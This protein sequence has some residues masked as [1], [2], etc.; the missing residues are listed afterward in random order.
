MKTKQDGGHSDIMLQTKLIKGKAKFY[1]YKRKFQQ[2]FVN[3]E[4]RAGKE[5]H[6]ILAEC[7]EKM[8]EAIALLGISLDYDIL[9]DEGSKLLDWAM[10]DCVSI[11]NKLGVC[12]RCLLCR[13]QRELRDSHIWPNFIVDAI[14]APSSQKKDF[15]FGLHKHLFKSPGECTYQMLCERCEQLLSQNGESDFKA[16][17]PTSGEITYSAWLFN[18]C[19]GVIFR[20][21]SITCQFPMHFNDGEIHKVLLHCRK[22]LLSLPV[23]IGGKVASLGAYNKRDLEKLAQQLKDN[24]DIYLFMSPLKSRQNYGAFQTEYQS[25]AIA[26]SRDKQFNTKSLHFNGNAHFYL[27]CCGP[28]TLIVNFDQS[29]LSL[30]K[31][32][33]LITSN[34]IDSD[35]KYSIPSEEDFV[36]LLPV[37]VWPIMEQLAQ[38]T[39]ENFNRVTQYVSKRAKLP[40]TRPTIVA[41]SGSGSSTMADTQIPAIHSM[42]DS[43]MMFPVSFLPKEYDVI[44]PHLK[45]P[46]NQCVILPQGHWVIC[47]ATKTISALNQDMTFLVCVKPNPEEL[48]VIY[49][50]QN[51]TNHTLCM[52]GA[53]AEFKNGQLILT[54]FLLQN[55]VTNQLR[56]SGISFLQKLLNIV[57][58]TKNFDNINLPLYLM[59]YRRCVAL[60]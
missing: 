51:N 7:F 37:G 39:I 14:D 2:V 26:L 52:D 32:G 45:L 4:I 23:T 10:I 15:I 40:E 41:P 58:P 38:G 53:V 43:R 48:C 16:K 56:R 25:T 12:K 54:S 44:N 21:L 17:F 18:F 13:Q 1:S 57:L 60:E 20:T 28:I 30:K 49:V 3:N 35:Q 5:G 9:D 55:Q 19:A 59:K 42:G 8:K 34:P 24:L 46:R 29:V 6:D 31:R 22:H 47:H 50:S 33:F 27:L 11:M 36:K